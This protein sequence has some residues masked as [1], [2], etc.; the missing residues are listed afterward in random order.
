[1][2]RKYTRE[3]ISNSGTRDRQQQHFVAAL[4]IAE[5]FSNFI[6]FGLGS[7]SVEL[8]VLYALLGEELAKLVQNLFFLLVLIFPGSLLPLDSLSLHPLHLQSPLHTRPPLPPP[9]PSTLSIPDLLDLLSP[10]PTSSL[11]SVPSPSCRYS[12]SHDEQKREFLLYPR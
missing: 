7:F 12:L 4:F 8:E 2:Q 3:I 10:L 6:F 9:R 5:F 11:S 1:V